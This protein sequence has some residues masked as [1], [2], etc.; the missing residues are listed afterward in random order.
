[1]ILFGLTG[2]NLALSYE[3]E[4]QAYTGEVTYTGTILGKD[5]PTVKVKYTPSQGGEDGK[6]EVLEWPILKEF[7]EVLDIVKGLIDAAENDDPGKCGGLGDLFLDNVSTKFK[8]NLSMAAGDGKRFEDPPLVTVTLSPNLEIRVAD[9]PIYAFDLLPIPLQFKGPFV[10]DGLEG[11]IE[12]LIK[13]SVTAIGDAILNNKGAFATLVSAMAVDKFGKEL[14]KRLLCRKCESE[15]VINKGEE[16]ADEDNG[17][18][19]DPGEEAAKDFAD[20]LESAELD[21]A[22]SLFA[23]GGTAFGT[24]M[25]VI[26]EFL[27]MAEWLIDLLSDPSSWRDKRDKAKA[28]RDALTDA[29]AKARAYIENAMD[30]SSNPAPASTFI[31]QTGPQ[32]Q[33]KVDWSNSKPNK[34]GFNY[35]GYRNFSW[36]VKA[37]TTGGVNDPSQ[38]QD[39]F[40]TQYVFTDSEYQYAATVYAW[41][42]AKYVSDNGDTFISTD[43]QPATVATQVPYLRPPGGIVFTITEQVATVA[44]Q[45]PVNGRYTIQ[46]AG[47]DSASRNS[48][49][50]QFNLFDSGSA[51]IHQLVMNIDVPP[52]PPPS[53]GA[54]V[55][56]VSTDPSKAHDSLFVMSSSAFTVNPPPANLMAEIDVVNVNVSW[57]QAGPPPPPP[58]PDYELVVTDI[59][60]KVITTATVKPLPI[61]IGHRKVQ[62]SSP[63]FVEGFQIIIFVR[64]APIALGTIGLYNRDTITI[65]D[66]LMPTITDGSFYDISS[67]TLNLNLI[68]DTSVS[69]S[70]TFIVQENFQSGP[71]TDP[72]IPTSIPLP[73]NSVLLQVPGFKAP[74]PVSVQVAMSSGTTHGPWSNSW[75]I[76]PAASLPLPAI[77]P[78]GVFGLE[79]LTLSWQAP[80]NATEILIEAYNDIPNHKVKK[81]TLPASSNTAVLSTGDNLQIYPSAR[82]IVRC[83]SLAQNVVGGSSVTP[84]VFFVTGGEGGK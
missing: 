17:K 14:I 19:V 25:G 76:P 8:I 3:T 35:N 78:Q 80:E 32:T 74:F 34:D 59:H 52:A 39:T 55:Q 63:D 10:V 58:T 79:S 1:L 15:E 36:T 50:Y 21:A 71:I 56:T 73:G 49:L 45:P 44:I 18:S 84:F 47:N 69:P 48:I 77:I 31:P 54:Y 24:F 4:D 75:L 65:S 16:I 62:L 57:D 11:A 23:T 70:A 38:Q 26:S 60:E 51:P 9:K 42:K 7:G 37:N 33:V 28:K 27:T 43:W 41:V 82:I 20:V 6:F 61:A 66:F 64:T 72:I 22:S 2:I 53:V 40:N 12:S 46:V 5:N 67:A 81:L 13:S 29:Q 83:T 30:L 68:F